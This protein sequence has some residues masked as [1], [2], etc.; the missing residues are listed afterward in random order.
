M[1]KNSL[2]SKIAA[3]VFVLVG[4]GA[5]LYETG[6]SNSEDLLS[7]DTSFV[8]QPKKRSPKRSD[9]NIF[10]AEFDR[11]YSRTSLTATGKF[12]EIKERFWTKEEFYK[13]LQKEDASEKEKLR[14]S[15]ETACNRD[16]KKA[17]VSW[18]KKRLNNDS[19]K[20]GWEYKE[21]MND[22]NKDW[23]TNKDTV[24]PEH[25][26]PENWTD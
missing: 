11:D 10:Q 26:K 17:F 8:S 19:Y 21:T 4:V 14:N 25:L 9:C 2:I 12:T 7:Q 20:D 6:N 23:L 24:V 3:G 22:N 13:E 15:I 5:V 16:G 1:L 18:E